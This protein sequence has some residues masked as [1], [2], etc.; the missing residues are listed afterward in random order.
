MAWL[1]LASAW[2]SRRDDYFIYGVF[3]GYVRRALSIVP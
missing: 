2:E 1:P 3:G